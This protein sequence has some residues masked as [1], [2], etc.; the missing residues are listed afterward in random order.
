[1]R[2]ASDGAIV[3]RRSRAPGGVGAVAV[4]PDGTIYTAGA[5][6]VSRE[7]IDADVVVAAYADD[8]AP[9]WTQRFAGE[10]EC[11]AHAIALAPGGDLYVAGTY[12]RSLAIGETDFELSPGDLRDAF[13]ARLTATGEVSWTRAE[14]GAERTSI[15]G[16]GVDDA[17]RL[18][19][20]GSRDRPHGRDSRR[21]SFLLQHDRDGAP[22]W[23]R[24]F[25]IDGRLRAAL[26]H[27]DVGVAIAGMATG[28]DVGGGRIDRES[29]FLARYT[30][31]GSLI[32]DIVVAE[33]ES[34]YGA[35]A[36]HDGALVAV[37]HLGLPDASCQPEAPRCHWYG[38]VERFQQI[39]VD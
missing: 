38:L 5:E 19:V 36:A 35:L 32:G 28:G 1:M 8:G 16:I 27:P 7:P 24:T 13:V 17:G 18:Y 31:D 25:E 14:F 15:A 11:A 26:V 30:S 23:E 29:R 9:R 21:A 37:G 6:V 3:W 33:R 39:S 2:I 10:G 20:A 34:D 22:R 4:A 12:A